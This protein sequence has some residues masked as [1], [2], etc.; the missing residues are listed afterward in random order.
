MQNFQGRKRLK[1]SLF[2]KITLVL[3]AGLVFILS[4]AVWGVY[5][6]NQLAEA[7][8]RQAEAELVELETQEAELKEKVAW[9][10]TERGQEEVIR[11]NFSVLKPGEKMIIVVDNNTATTAAAEP[12]KTNGWWQAAVG[13]I[14]GLFDW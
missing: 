5:A 10:A 4:K 13:A 7:G 12:A 11:R 6:K 1:R 8:R 14:G 3:L 9:L 2:S